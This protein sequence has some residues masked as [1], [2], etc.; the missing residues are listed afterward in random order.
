MTHEFLSI[1]LGA[2]R[3]SVSIVIEH[4]SRR[5]MLKVERGRILIGDRDELLK[6]SCDCYQVIKHNYEQVG[7]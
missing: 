6:V 2:S 5:G 7:Q 1:L 4:F 3:P